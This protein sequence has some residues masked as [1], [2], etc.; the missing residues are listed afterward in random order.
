MSLFSKQV[1]ENEASQ[2]RQRVITTDVVFD[3]HVRDL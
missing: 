3:L 2:I 1:F